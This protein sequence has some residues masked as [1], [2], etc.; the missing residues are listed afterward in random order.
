M[1][2]SFTRQ[3]IKKPVLIV[4]CVRECAQSFILQKRIL[5]N[6]LRISYRIKIQ[7]F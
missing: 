2:D 3:L 1:R 4:A 6:E 5:L 7:K